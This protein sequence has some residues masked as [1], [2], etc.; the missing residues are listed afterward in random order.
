MIWMSSLL[1][2]ALVCCLHHI[3]RYLGDSAG[4][5]QAFWLVVHQ[6][7]GS[8]INH[9][10]AVCRSIVGKY[11]YDIYCHL[12][13][14]VC[15][16]FYFHLS[17]SG[18][19]VLP[20]AMNAILL[21]WTFMNGVCLKTIWLFGKATNNRTIFI[22]NYVTIGCS[23]KAFAIVLSLLAHKQYPTWITRKSV[24]Q[25]PIAV[26]ETLPA[27]WY[28]TLWTL[29]I[30]VHRGHS[31]SSNRY[32]QCVFLPTRDSENSLSEIFSSDGH[33]FQ[34]RKSL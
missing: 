33:A 16:I 30:H 18:Y 26:H 24:K 4:A 12:S 19:F 31:S 20:F 28:P 9:L 8:W 11:I 2:N 5:F 27:A 34:W 7:F 22:N 6:L 23:V 32:L 29:S 1:W 3:C 21:I 15:F 13:I 14:S 25:T 17:N 10:P